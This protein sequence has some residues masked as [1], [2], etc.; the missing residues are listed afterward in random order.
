VLSLGCGDEPYTVS[1]SMMKWGGLLSWKKAIN[2]ATAF[3]SRNA[4]GQT[5]LLI[6][7]ER[8]LRIIPEV[9]EPPIEL[10][11]WRRAKDVLPSAALSAFHHHA[12]AITSHFLGNHK[13]D[14]E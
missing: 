8:V 1:D 11:D 12:E 10:D 4:L 13:R 3:Q 5:R 2:G 7:A 6:G 14:K 9:V